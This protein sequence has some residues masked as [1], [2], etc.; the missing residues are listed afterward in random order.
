MENQEIEAMIR[1]NVASWLREPP[2]LA[3]QHA[4]LLCLV[5]LLPYELSYNTGGNKHHTHNRDDYY[6]LVRHRRN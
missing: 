4:S 3:R 6:A 5:H 1:C 2:G